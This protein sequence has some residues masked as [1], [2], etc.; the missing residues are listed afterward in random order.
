MCVSLFCLSNP[1]PLKAI[2]SKELITILE[3][4]NTYRN[5]W[6]GHGGSVTSEEAKSRHERIRE[7]LEVFR[8]LFGTVFTKYELIKLGNPRVL[9]GP[10][11]R[12]PAKRVMGSNPMLESQ[13]VEL[14]EPAV[15]GQL[16]CFSP[17][18]RRALELYP[19]F[20]LKEM[21]Q[22]ACYFFNRI[23]KAVP[24]YVSYHPVNVPEVED[25]GQADVIWDIVADFRDGSI[26]V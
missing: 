10:V 19:L 7:Q 11:Y 13:T 21:P 20:Q 5:H 26:T 14:S 22:A 2:C 6:T 17:G 24:R 18:Q 9:P 23:E 25:V 8:H 12:Y 4:A 15:S 3:Q 1:E 16:H